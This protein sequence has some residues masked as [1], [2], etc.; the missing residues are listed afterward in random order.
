MISRMASVLSTNNTTNHH[1]SPLR[2]ESQSAQPFQGSVQ[3]VSSIA[4]MP[5]SAG[6]MFLVYTTQHEV[7]RC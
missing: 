6:I 4:Y 7:S 1:F 2:A 5:K 3:S